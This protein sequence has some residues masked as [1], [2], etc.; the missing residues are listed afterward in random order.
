MAGSAGV[1]RCSCS[2]SAVVDCQ[3]KAIGADR[4]DGYCVGSRRSAIANQRHR[5]GVQHFS[6]E[7]M[8]YLTRSLYQAQRTPFKRE[9]AY[10]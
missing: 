10:N 6:S 1:A 4:N 7:V 9:F 3:A 2:S 5:K 8:L